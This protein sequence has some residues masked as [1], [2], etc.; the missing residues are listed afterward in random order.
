[1]RAFLALAIIALVAAILYMIN[2]GDLKDTMRDL[3]MIVVGHVLSKFSGV[4]DFYFGS[5]DGSKQKTDQ[6]A[7]AGNTL[8]LTGSE[9]E[10]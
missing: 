10:Q 7:A 6:M 9:Q 5:S 2:S 8:D 3:A 4:Y 1:M